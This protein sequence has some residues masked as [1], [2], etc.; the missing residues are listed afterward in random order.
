MKIFYKP[1]H[2]RFYP[3]RNSQRDIMFL[4]LVLLFTY[5][6]FLEFPPSLLRAFTMMFIGFILYDRYIEVFSFYSLG[7]TVV[8]LL[9]L[10]PSLLFS[11]GFWFSVVGVFNLFLVLKHFADLQKWKLFILL[12][13]GVFVLMTPWVIYI[14]GHFNSEQLYSPVLSMLFILFYPLVLLLSIFDQVELFDVGLLT[15]LNIDSNLINIELSLT[16]FS[17]FIIFS[18]VSTFFKQAFIGLILLISSLLFFLIFVN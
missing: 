6:T 3:Y 9:V 18:I 1:L 7:L 8:F 10:F 5:V 13:I 4:T 14:F 12:H 2:Q 17:F 15:L 11:L 16:A